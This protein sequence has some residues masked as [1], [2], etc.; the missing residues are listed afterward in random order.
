MSD[1]EDSSGPSPRTTDLVI[2]AFQGLYQTCRDMQEQ[3]V[4]NPA[5]ETLSMD[6]VKFRTAILAQLQS[7]LLPSL[8]QDFAH[9]S[10]SLD[11]NAVGDIINPRLKDTLAIT[12]RLNDTLNQ[13]ENAINTIAPMPVLGGLKP[14]TSDEKYGLVKEHRCQDLLN[15]FI[16][17]MYHYVSVLFQKHK[18]LVRNLG[19][20]RNRQTIG[21]DDQSVAGSTRV[22]RLRKEIIE[23]TEDFSQSIHRLIEKSQR[24]DFVILQRSWQLDVEVLDEQLADLTQMNNVAIYWEAR[25]DLIDVDPMVARHLRA[26]SSKIIE[27]I[28]TLVKLFRIFYTRLLDTPKGKADFTLDGMSSA[29]WAMMRFVTGYPFSRISKVVEI[30]C[31]TCEPGETVNRKARQLIGKAEELPSLFDSCLVLIGFHLVP[32][33]AA[34][35]YTFKTNFSTLRGAIR[36]AMDHLKSAALEQHNLRM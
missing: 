22:P 26:L 5:T 14:H 32:S 24:S 27:S 25:R 36:T 19:S 30:A 34:L 16:P 33:D 1:Y 21:P 9:L 4:G 2:G 3:R 28:I 13:I 31:S 17:L 8:V 15:T 29:D 6:E 23:M 12:A 35:E 7:N 10:E 18:R 20:L 11:L